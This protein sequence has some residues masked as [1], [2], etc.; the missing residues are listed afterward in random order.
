MKCLEPALDSSLVD[1]LPGRHWLRQAPQCDQSKIPAVEETTDQSACR[2]IDNDAVGFSKS[3]Q[4]SGQIR[5]LANRGLL[6]CLARAN[7]LA[8]N[9]Q[10]GG[11]PDA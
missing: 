2:G 1:H 4:A 6:S 5:R 8:N 11:N 3:L 9:H 7:R 10:A